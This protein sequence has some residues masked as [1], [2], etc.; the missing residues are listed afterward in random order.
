MAGG[1]IGVL[2]N[3]IVIA[4]LH[5]HRPRQQVAVFAAQVHDLLVEMATGLDG[6]WDEAA[7]RHWYQVGGQI[8]DLAPHVV[9]EIQTGQ[10]STRLNPRDSL[11]PVQVDWEGYAATVAVLRSALWQ[12]TG[13]ARTLVDAADGR[14]RQPAPTPGFLHDYAR[15]LLAISEAISQVGLRTPQAAAAFDQQADR[16]E[17]SDRPPGTGPTNTPGG[18]RAVAGL[19]IPD[20]RRAARHQRPADRT[21]ASGPADRQRPAAPDDLDHSTASPGPVRRPSQTT[22]PTGHDR[23]NENDSSTGAPGPP[24]SNCKRWVR[25]R[26]GPRS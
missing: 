20:H 11:R 21:V 24:T 7:A 22:T 16:A 2:T 3:A 26:P 10:E 19:R 25:R 6:D 4:P 14:D 18:P 23:P 12:V 1:A 5:L 17:R 13:I 9:E 8:G 15:G